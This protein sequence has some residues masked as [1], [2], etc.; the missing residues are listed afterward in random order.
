MNIWAAIEV[1]AFKYWREISIAIMALGLASSVLTT[2]ETTKKLNDKIQSETQLI[3]N[4]KETRDELAMREDQVDKDVITQRDLQS[5][6][7]RAET[8]AKKSTPVLLANG[9]VAYETT[10]E[11]QMAEDSSSQE[12]AITETKLSEAHKATEEALLQVDD[13]RQALTA[14]RSVVKDLESSRPA[15]KHWLLTMGAQGLGSDSVTGMGGAGGAFDLGA[16]AIGALVQ[17]PVI[18]PSRPIMPS[19]TAAW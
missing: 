12:K 19:I 1:W 5:Q 2:K 6:V 9:A 17:F 15:F 16:V 10:V 11:S 3:A 13:E 8:I 18:G 14:A 4:L 7:Q